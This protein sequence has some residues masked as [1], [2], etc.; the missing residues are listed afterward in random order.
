MVLSVNAVAG[1][2]LPLLNSKKTPKT[3]EH[4]MIDLDLMISDLGLLTEA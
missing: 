3:E 2:A 4:G 1:V